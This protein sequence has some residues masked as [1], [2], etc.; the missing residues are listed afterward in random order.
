M[1]AAFRVHLV[2]NVEAGDPGILQ[3][4]HSAG[5]IHRFAE[6]GVGVDDRGQVGH[7]RNLPGTPGDL[8]ERGETDVGKP[9]VG[10]QHRS[11]DVD[12]IEALVLDEP[13]RQRVECAG[14]AE[15]LAARE[16]RPKRR[17][18]LRDRGSGVQHQ[19]SPFGVTTWS[20]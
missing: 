9:E 13:R 10:A 19:N 5:H 11:R 1:P 16:P 4:L 12:A 18:L 17:A 6:P 8:G 7:A 20:R 3:L 2:F 14:E 15:Q